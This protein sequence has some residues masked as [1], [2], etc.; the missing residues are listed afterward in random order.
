MQKLKV[1]YQ[2]SPAQL[3]CLKFPYIPV[4]T[5]YHA[6]QIPMIYDQGFV[7][8]GECFKM[9]RSVRVDLTSFECNSENRRLIR[10]AQDMNPHIELC[11]KD[12]DRLILQ[13]D[14]INSCIEFSKQRYVDNG[15]LTRH[16]YWEI[17]HNPII[18]DVVS[19]SLD[20]TRRGTVFL[21][22]HGNMMHYWHAF[23]DLN[24]NQ[25]EQLALGKYLMLQTILYA[26][27]MGKS[28]LYLGAAYDHSDYYKIN[29]W[30]SLSWWDGE[31][32][33]ADTACL[34]N[35]CKGHY[36]TYVKKQE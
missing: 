23:Y 14:F 3:S 33:S 20:G 16:S 31:K 26:Q 24:F 29:D 34:K 10:K 4:I 6:S 32:W 9:A 7:A 11:K 36:Q 13:D 25:I 17:Y 27:K 30:H 5:D 8:F 21:C 1:I 35:L 28:H 18:T 19:L 2:E 22:N 15:R 12:H